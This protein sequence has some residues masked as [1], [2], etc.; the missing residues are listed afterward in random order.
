MLKDVKINRKYDMEPNAAT[1]E[2]DK[3]PFKDF[4]ITMND[5]QTI[6]I[7]T[8]RFGRPATVTIYRASSVP[9]GVF[10]RVDLSSAT[11]KAPSKYI[12]ADAKTKESLALAY[13]DVI[14]PVSDFTPTPINIEQTPPATPKMH[15]KDAHEIWHSLV[16]VASEA[17]YAGQPVPSEAKEKL[18]DAIRIAVGSAY[19]PWLQ[20]CCADFFE[21]LNS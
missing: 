10:Q 3:K 17:F 6:A 8:L 21:W 13:T 7:P 19:L 15:P 9:P 16:Q 12:I 5:T 11:T 18:P 1:H 4:M 20:T 14:S 2:D